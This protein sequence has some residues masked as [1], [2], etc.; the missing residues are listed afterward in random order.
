MHHKEQRARSLAKALTYR[1]MSIFIDYS[2]VFLITKE[3]ETS[4]IITLI[5]NA[6]SFLMY[7]MHERAW[8]RVKW[9]RRLTGQF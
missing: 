1:L 6:M 2:V 7:F 5:T 4:L 9:G 3:Y 8:N